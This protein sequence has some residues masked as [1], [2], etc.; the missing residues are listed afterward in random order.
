MYRIWPTN[1][2]TTGKFTPFAKET[3]LSAKLQQ[4]DCML[5]GS[6]KVC[7]CCKALHNI[8]SL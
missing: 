5:C 8:P 6:C 7:T 4:E 1:L 2:K 3:Q